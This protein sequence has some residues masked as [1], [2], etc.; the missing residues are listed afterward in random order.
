MRAQATPAVL[1]L[2]RIRQ[3]PLP[4]DS[5]VIWPGQPL[6]HPAHRLSHAGLAVVHGDQLV[7]EGDR[8]MPPPGHCMPSRGSGC[9]SAASLPSITE[10]GQNRPSPSRRVMSMSVVMT[11]L[12]PSSLR[13]K[14]C[15]VVPRHTSDPSM[16]T[17]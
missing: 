12:L 6:L 10:G 1:A 11:H 7:L 17:M 5:F 2:D 15:S 8:E 3:P 13:P 9:H 16:P 14:L 4:D